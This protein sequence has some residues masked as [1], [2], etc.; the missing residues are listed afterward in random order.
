M[1]DRLSTM[2]REEVGNGVG[3][4]IKVMEDH[5]RTCKRGLREYQEGDRTPDEL[6][7]LVLHEMSWGW[8]NA[9][10][11]LENAIRNTGRGYEAE[12]VEAERRG[13]KG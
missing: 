8:A 11:R 6:T 9:S 10:T 3:A 13:V 5:L 2:Y 1:T 4:C 7:T 12:K